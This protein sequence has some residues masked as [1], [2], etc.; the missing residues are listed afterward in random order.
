MST[1]AHVHA[2]LGD[3]ALLD[4]AVFG[5]VNCL[6][7]GISDWT[8]RLRKEMKSSIRSRGAH[9]SLY[10]F[11]PVKR[12]EPRGISYI[13]GY[14]SSANNAFHHVRTKTTKDGQSLIAVEKVCPRC[15]IAYRSV[16]ELE[17]P[18]FIRLIDDY[19]VEAAAH[20]DLSN[21]IIA[22]ISDFE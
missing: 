19:I 13:N 6:Q 20:L 11:A 14:I 18:E 8:D 16:V 10:V 17:C 12:Y 15:G 2:D 7:A 22:S 5:F 3:Y 21:R 4:T 9:E 1:P